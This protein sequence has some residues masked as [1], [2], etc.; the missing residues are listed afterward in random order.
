MNFKKGIAHVS[1][2]LNGF[3]TY[4]VFKI[5]VFKIGFNMEK[6]IESKVIKRIKSC[7]DNNFN[8]AKVNSTG[9]LKDNFTQP[10]SAKKIKMTLKFLRV[11]MQRL[12]NVKRK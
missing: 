6:K 7:F 11:I 3:L 1:I 9:S 10:L 5:E 12:V 8:P 2:H 4:Q